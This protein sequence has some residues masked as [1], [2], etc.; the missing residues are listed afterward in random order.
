IEALAF[1]HQYQRPLTLFETGAPSPRPLEEI[2]DE[3]LDGVRVEATL[4]DYAMAYEL[5][6]ELLYETLAEL[7]KPLRDFLAAI[8]ELAEEQGG[9]IPGLLLPEELA[10][11]LE[12]LRREAAERRP[13]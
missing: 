10:E 2:P 12:Q 6:S 7:K 9:R 4:D 11:K 8:R 5:A 1:L 3:E 13:S